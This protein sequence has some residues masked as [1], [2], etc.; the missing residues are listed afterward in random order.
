MWM[1]L[2]WLL[3]GQKR[4]LKMVVTVLLDVMSINGNPVTQVF[5]ETWCI[6]A[7]FGAG[8]QSVSGWIQGEGHGYSVGRESEAVPSH[9]ASAVALLVA[10][11][12][13]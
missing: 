12:R 13:T 3:A 11:K 9:T 8:R 7:A 1:E 4:F 10:L 6:V 5:V 2:A